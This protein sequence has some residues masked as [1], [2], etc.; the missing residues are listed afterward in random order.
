MI[1]VN[2]MNSEEKIESVRRKLLSGNINL[3]KEDEEKFLDT[4]ENP[5]EPNE[6][7]KKLERD[8]E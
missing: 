1:V 5:S 3:S 8:E 4:L 6:A 2:S 7:L